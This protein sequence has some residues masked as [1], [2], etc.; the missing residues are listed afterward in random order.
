MNVVRVAIAT[1]ALAAAFLG[2]LV[3]E[4]QHAKPIEPS[5]RVLYYVDPMHP[6]YKSDKPGIAPDCGMKLVPF[7]ADQVPSHL[8]AHHLDLPEGTIHV[9]LE[10]QQLIGVRYGLAEMTSGEDSIRAVGTVAVDE[11][12]LTRIHPKFDGWIETVYADFTG[13][14]V[15]AGE[16]LLTI[17]SPDMQTEQRDFLIAVKAR[18]AQSAAD[19][20]ALNTVVESAMQRLE[21]HDF[22]H[23]QRAGTSAVT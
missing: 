18:D 13:V 23:D 15:K 4:R 9:D 17:F 1:L 19:Q 22:T 21:L 14:V 20:E 8:G 11:T 5:R 7:Y 6:A 3:Y 2:G 10:K 12:R 16:P